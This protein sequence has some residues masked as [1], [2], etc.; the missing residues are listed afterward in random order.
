[1]KDTGLDYDMCYFYD[2]NYKEPMKFNEIILNHRKIVG[3]YQ[4]KDAEHISDKQDYA[5]GHV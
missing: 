3:Y 4:N 1:L 5:N 2:D